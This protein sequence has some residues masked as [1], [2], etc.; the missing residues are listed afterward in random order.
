MEGVFSPLDEVFEEVQSSS[1]RNVGHQ[2]D[3]SCE[4]DQFQQSRLVVFNTELEVVLKHTHS[5][6]RLQFVR[7]IVVEK[8]QKL[9][10]RNGTLAFGQEKFGKLEVGVDG[11]VLSQS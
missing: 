8:Q 5:D 10:N 1:K 3:D 11:L 4:Y 7:K 6:D 2:E 9:G